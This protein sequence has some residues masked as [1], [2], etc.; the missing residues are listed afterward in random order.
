MK[1]KVLLIDTAYPINGR[2]EKVLDSLKNRYPHFEYHIV[3][4]NRQL[5]DI[6]IPDNYHLYQKRSDLGA[7]LKK[8]INLFGFKRY[9]RSIVSKVSP[10]IIYASHWDSLYTLPLNISK[11]IFV[12][13]D[14]IDVP[15]GGFVRRTIGRI[16]E[17]I[18]INKSNLIV[19]ASRFFEELYSNYHISKCIIENKPRLEKKDRSDIPSNPLKI[20]YLGNIRYVE[21][22]VP[23]IKVVANDP[24][25]ILDFY[26]GGPDCNFLKK[27]ECDNIRFHGPYHYSE[28]ETFYLSSDIVWAAYPNKDF[29]VKYAISN[30]FHESLNFSTP[31]IYAENTKLGDY[32]VKERIGFVVN[33]Y[34]K[35]SVKQLLDDIANDPSVILDVRHNIQK[36]YERETTWED[37]MEYIYAVMKNI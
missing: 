1:K 4:W 8:F 10:D 2:T 35:A 14:N 16:L 24:R 5:L 31:G 36:V 37:D 21:T 32:I 20:A 22:L 28:V 12:I 29:N 18:S 30:K 25:Y 27:Y 17:R 9:V 7:R 34:E 11:D 3:S 13:Y 33:P 19:F 26:G 23:L 6:S 15:D